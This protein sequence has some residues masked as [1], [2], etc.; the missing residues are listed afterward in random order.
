MPIHHVPCTNIPRIQPPLRP[1]LGVYLLVL[2]GTVQGDRASTCLY[3]C[4]YVYLV[5]VS[6]LAQSLPRL[7]GSMGVG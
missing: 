5:R 4:M 7:V 1:Y 3:A 2:T 6:L